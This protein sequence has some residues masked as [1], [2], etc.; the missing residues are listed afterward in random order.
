MD[1]F[2]S[3]INGPV[4]VVVDFSAEWCGPCKMMKPILSQLKSSMGDRVRIL[5]VDV[6]K[7]PELAARNNIR[8]V[9]TIKIYQSGREKWSGSG[10]VQADRLEMII[11]NNSQL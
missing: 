7:N 3:I 1:N 5:K 4:P 2:S 6:D 11:K 9:P 8:S 10:V